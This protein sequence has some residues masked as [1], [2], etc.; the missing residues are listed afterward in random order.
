MK[1]IENN[2]SNI[3]LQIDKIKQLRAEYDVKE[4]KYFPFSKDPS[5]PIPGTIFCVKYLK[6]IL[7]VPSYYLLHKLICMCHVYIFQAQ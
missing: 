3:Q 4:V 6:E 5:K 7:T 1:V 2:S